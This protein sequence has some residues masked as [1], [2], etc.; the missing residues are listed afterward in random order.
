MRGIYAARRDAL[1]AGLRAFSRWLEPI[2]NVAGLHLSAY[3]ND[4][5]DVAALADLARR[6]DVGVS[7]IRNFYFGT[8][9]RQG[10]AF[11][12]GA[13][14]ERRIDE[15]CKRLVRAWPA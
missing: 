9:A 11:G 13:I 5:V 7:P 15:A 4:S 14:D 12:Y 8:P 1:L 6:H 10:L 3:A 2:P